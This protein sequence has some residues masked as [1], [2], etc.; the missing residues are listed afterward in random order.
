MEEVL[1]QHLAYP[2]LRLEELEAIFKKVVEV[3]RVELE[4]S[5]GV[6]LGDLRDFLGVDARS[7]RLPPRGD[8]LDWLRL[9]RRLGDHLCDHFLFREV[10]GVLRNRLYDFAYEL[11]LVVL[12]ENLEA[13]RIADGGAIPPE[14][15]RAYRV[16]SSRPYRRDL[17]ANELLRPFAHLARRAVREGKK[18]YAV[19]GNAI[20]YEKRDAV[21]E[22]ARLA[23]SCGRE[24]EK[25]PFAR[26]SRRAL[27]GVKQFREI[28]HPQYYTIR[29]LGKVTPSANL[30]AFS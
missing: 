1:L 27:L 10:L 24:H 5:R 14:E 16:E 17:V 18:E 15:P 22:R 7:L 3:H 9:V 23:G 25:R 2:V 6:L 29:R 4:L 13:A 20:L 11:L 12:V 28:S 21:D 30:K 26:R 8:H 19:G